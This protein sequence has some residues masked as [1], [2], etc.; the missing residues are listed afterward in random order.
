MCSRSDTALW[1]VVAPGDTYVGH[2]R[3]LR[4][5]VGGCVGLGFSR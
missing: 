2:G 3:D 4:V 5:K 1:Q